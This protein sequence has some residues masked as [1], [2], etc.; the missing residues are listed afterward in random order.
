MKGCLLFV[1]IFVLGIFVMIG[2][3]VYDFMYSGV[4]FQDSVVAHRPDEVQSERARLLQVGGLGLSFCAI[5]GAAGWQF[6]R[7]LKMPDEDESPPS[8]PR[9]K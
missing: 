9:P 8:A 6:Y 3:F 7:R 2:G 1:A 5:F 4:P